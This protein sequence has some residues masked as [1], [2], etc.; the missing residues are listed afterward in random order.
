MGIWKNKLTFI[1][2]YWFLH[3]LGNVAYCTFVV[4]FSFNAAEGQR[5]DSEET[6]GLAS[7]VT[8][9]DGRFFF[10]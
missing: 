8:R 3:N 10:G 5:V 2:N 1:Y 9:R 6:V 4:F 7:Q